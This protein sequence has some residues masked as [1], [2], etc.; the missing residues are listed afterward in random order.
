MHEAGYA[1]TEERT[2]SSLTARE[3]RRLIEGKRV[4]N[5]IQAEMREAQQR[6]QAGDDALGTAVPR[7][8][9]QELLED[10]EN[11]RQRGEV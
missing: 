11:R 2:I 4:N 1:Y 10:F 9:D 6:E 8:S 5:E 7:E 3:Q